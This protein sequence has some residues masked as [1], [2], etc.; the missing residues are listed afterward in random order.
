MQ[1]LGEPR[2]NPPLDLVEDVR[3]RS[4]TD[5][6]D[7][8][9]VAA[10]VQDGLVCEGSKH[11]SSLVRRS[12]PEQVVASKPRLTPTD[13]LAHMRFEGGQVAAKANDREP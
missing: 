4:S 9:V 10:G 2:G 13:S 6:Y 1:D 7:D 12:R 3:H 11:D 8:V 5:V